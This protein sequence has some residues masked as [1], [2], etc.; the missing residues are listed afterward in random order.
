DLRG[1]RHRF[2]LD[3]APRSRKTAAGL[4]R[5]PVERAGT[6]TWSREDR[7]NGAKKHAGTRRGGGEKAGDERVGRG[8]TLGENAVGSVVSRGLGGEGDRLHCSSSPG[9]SVVR[10]F[11]TAPP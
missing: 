3:D 10:G 5:A 4:P 1:G 11:K 6:G 9:W 7:L 2:P 8:P